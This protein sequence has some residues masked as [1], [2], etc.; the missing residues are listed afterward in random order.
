MADN[1]DTITKNISRIG[2]QADKLQ[3]LSAQAR[4]AGQEDKAQDLATQAVLLMAK[5]AT[6]HMQRRKIVTSSPAW[7]QLMKHLDDLDQKAAATKAD[8]E[9]AKDTVETAKTV[10]GA[11]G[12][13]LTVL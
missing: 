12:K 8:M 4:A 6:L 7:Q 13:V 1:L 10:I 9:K 2:V 5:K 3:A 11:L